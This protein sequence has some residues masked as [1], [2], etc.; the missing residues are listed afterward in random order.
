MHFI[1][2]ADK[3]SGCEKYEI[4]FHISIALQIKKQMGKGSIQFKVQNP[5]PVVAVVVFRH[6]ML[7]TS[8]NSNWVSQED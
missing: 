1:H 3:S 7:S 5:H 8:N 6:L 2:L 4:T